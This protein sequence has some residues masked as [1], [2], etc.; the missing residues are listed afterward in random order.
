MT[1][2]FFD[3]MTSAQGVTYNAAVDTIVF[4]H[5]GETAGTIAVS[6]DAS[7]NPVLTS[8]LTGHSVAF[9]AGLL[10]EADFAFLDGSRLTVGAGGTIAGTA[11]NDAIHSSLQYANTLDGGAGDDTL[12]GSA[13]DTFSGGPG[14]DLFVI[15][16]AETALTSMPYIFGWE[17]ADHIRFGAAPATAGNYL[18]VTSSA[19]RYDFALNEAYAYIS[20]G[21][22]DYVV[23]QVLN[24]VLIFVDSRGDNTV[25]DMV[26]IADTTLDEI[27]LANIVSG[28]PP[29]PAAPPPPA[30]PPVTPFASVSLTGGAGADLLVGSAAADTLNGGGG[31][32]T[33]LPGGGDDVL[34]GG[35]GVDVVSYINAAEGVAVDLRG[36]LVQASVGQGIDRLSNIEN[37][38]GSQFDDVLTG[39]GGANHLW[40]WAGSDTLS[41]G[42]GA[43]TLEGREGPDSLAGG[44]GADLLIADGG[45]DTLSG[46][47]GADVFEFIPPAEGRGAALTGTISR[48]DYIADWIGA[49]DKILI[50]GAQAGT[51]GNYREGVADSLA[52]GQAMATAAFQQTFPIVD[53]YAIQIGSDTVVFVKDLGSA[54]VLVDRSI[55]DISGANFRSGI[56]GPPEISATPGSW[57]DDHV[58]LGAGN[59]RFDANAGAD[60]VDAGAGVDTVLGGLGADTVLGG[61]GADSIDGGPGA[62]YLRGDDGADVIAGG[63]DFDDING[64]MGNDT[65]HGG[66]GGDWVVGGK[67]QDLLFGDAGDDIVYGN[68]GDDTC[69]GGAGA[70]LVRGGQGADLLVG[71]DGDDWISG[72]R[73]DDTMTGGA[74]ADVFHTFGD[75][76]ID[77]VLDF[78]AVE[79][80]RIQLDPGTQYTVAQ[81]GADTV[82]SMTGGGQMILV[83]VQLST[84]PS[85]WIFGA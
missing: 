15:G 56:L 16:K 49:D 53:Y 5:P 18:E 30:P 2:Y 32:D 44:E 47:T 1:T 12:V 60:S 69:L 13:S 24:D 71:A 82:I 35:A 48:F 36:G 27:S 70:D 73:G 55:G 14:A 31:D 78:T 80:D 25:G 61:A 76:G 19:Q 39:D 34:D 23:M 68:L 79:G 84:L 63:E 37:I 64:N 54:I 6:Y 50:W 77:R 38:S 66:G 11:A 28:A 83:G 57:G 40:G 10:G 75:A 7:G 85:G 29:A 58:A 41:G 46:G 65:A 17:T 45:G 51:T 43:D 72:D 67:D 42:A 81:V 62:G 3:A 8:T 21:V 59:D 33:L 74:G 4:T 52:A 26:D 20:R 9:G 22:A